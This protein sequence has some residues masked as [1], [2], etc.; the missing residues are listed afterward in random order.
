LTC[1]VSAFQA[2]A[3]PKPFDVLI[4]NGRIVD[5]TGNP[6][7]VADVGIRD[8]IIVEIGTLTDRAALRVIDARNLTVVPGFIDMMGGSSLPLLLDPAS[9][10]SKLRQGITTMM[11]GEGD[12]LAPQNERT[13]KE[14]FDGPSLQMTWRTYDEYFRML[15]KKGIGLNVVHNV[16]AAQIRRVVIG[17][18]DRAP[19]PQQLAQMKDLVEQAMKDGANGLS[20]ALIYPPGTYAKTEEIIELARVAARRGGIYFSH[21]RNESNRLLEAIEETIRIGKEA[22]IPVHI[23]HLK[24]AGEENWPLMTQALKRIQ[25]AR[26][27]GIDITAD[28][29]PYVR[30]GI[31][32]RAF[33]HPRHYAEGTDAFLPTLLNAEV[34]KS[35]RQEIETTSDWENWYRHVGKNWDNVLIASAGPKGDAAL[36]GLSIQEVASRRGADAWDVFFDLIQGADVFVCPRSMD[37]EQKRQALRA[38]FVAIDTDA[39][40]INPATAAMSLS[41]SYH[42]RAFGA[43]PRVLA[44]YVREERVISLEDAVRKMSSLAA[45]RLKLMDRGRIGSGMKAD[46]VIFDPNKIQDKAT[47][48]KPLSFSVGIDYVLVNG[49]LAIDGAHSTGALAGTVIRNRL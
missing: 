19:T 38:P 8:G 45:N 24:A 11:V 49:K 31:G 1:L 44:Q 34:R 35:I 48:A 13:M 15:E 17:D 14:V 37:E 46:I 2:F 4:K 33:V 20:T 7:Y 5:G 40:P 10:E 43:F 9:A 42:P 25:E 6:W 18:E 32:L 22:G 41:Q 26:E 28:I 27:Q 16:G 21:M 39:A 3:Q 30:N 29:Y 12:S 36:S 23:Y 47:F